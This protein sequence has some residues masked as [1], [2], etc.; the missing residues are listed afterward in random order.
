MHSSVD[1]AATVQDV[2]I[3]VVDDIEQNL[4]A[5][6]ALLTRPGVRVLKAASGVAALEIL[7]VQEV[8][9]ILL[10]VQMPN[11]DGFELAELVR[12]NPHTTAIP[13]IFMT[14]ANKEPQRSFQGYQAG[15]VDFLYKPVE[16]DILRSKVNVFVELYAQRRQ[17]SAQLEELRQALHVNEI[18]TAVLG[19]DLRNPLA[20]VLN[21]AELLLLMPGDKKVATVASR[22][23]SSARRME[24]MVSQLLDVARIRAGGVALEPGRGDY[25]Q[26]CRRIADELKH[27]GHA[28]PVQIACTGNTEGLFDPDRIG[29]VL[30]NLLGNA[31]Q[32]GEP[33]DDVTIRIDG[34]DLAQLTLSIHNRGAVP[35]AVLEQAF[36]P[37]R[38][39][40]EARSQPGLGL[41]LYIAK[42]FVDAHGGSIVLDSSVANGT[43]FTL[44]LP[45]EAVA[46]AGAD[47]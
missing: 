15:A 3:L 45:R 38:P 17:L 34:S 41:G 36:T 43:T 33:A 25:A 22:I 28:N 5:I 40:R 37:F 27:A 44:R 16:P 31:L 13:L 32:H 1:H 20:A 23:R 29:Q 8:A 19:H 7:L 12:G 47:R 46:V 10:D 6:E 24:K 4:V 26:L 35:A 30:S 9:L 39:G 2:P 21:G 11:M 18:F 42:Y 14:A